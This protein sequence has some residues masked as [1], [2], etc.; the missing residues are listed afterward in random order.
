MIK[1]FKKFFDF[2][3]K[4]KKRFYVSLIFSLL[5]SIFEASRI[6]AIAVVLKAVIKDTMSPS[7]IWTSLLIMLVSIAG[8]AWT[9]KVTT[10]QQTIAGYT[11]CADK[12]VEIGERMKYMPMGYFNNNNLGHIASIT[13]NTC[14]NLQDI[15]T[16]VI[17]MYLQGMLTTTVISILLLVFDVRIGITAVLGILAFLLLNHQMQK[18][19]I[20]ISPKKTIAD[21]ALVD[22]VLEY[23]QGITV[24][25]SYNLGK[26]ANKKVDRKIDEANDICYTL[27][28]KFI[29]FMCGQTVV[30]KLFAL[31]MIT[32]SVVF[33]L[34]GSM[35]LIN[36]LLMIISSFIVYGQ[37]E[38]AGMYSALLRVVDQS[39][40]HIAEIFDTPVMDVN[41]VKVEPKNH[42][43]RAE[44]VT[45]SYDDRKII[46][47]V[48]FTIP[49]KTT[50]AIVG[51]SGGGKTTICSLISRF[52]DVNSGSITIG[53]RNVKE[54]TLDSLL[55]NISMVFQN[56]YLFHDTIENNIKFGKPDATRE[57]V[58]EAAKKACCHEFIENLPDGYQTVI[59]EA[60]AT[61]SGGEK[62]RISIARAILKDAPIIILD[63]ATANVDPENEKHLQDAI[64]ELTKDK[65][66]IMIA[67]RL[68]TVRSASQILVLSGGNILQ[69]G[70]HEQLMKEGGIYADFVNMRSK[71]IG[72]KLG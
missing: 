13:T 67:H 54:Y 1:I 20:K 30:F 59:G 10:M 40:D 2:S 25:K 41:G 61:I 39:V 72:W 53:G 36:A 34:N 43:I 46:D 31:L 8:C 32:L 62:Q 35:S 14:E 47:D 42:D 11:M 9:R 58:I 65:T 27:E 45:F 50:T 55:N 4:Q 24:V 52:W 60:G 33:C 37:L 66:I 5:H 19:S 70:N 18:V 21:I 57:Q 68:K 12:R 29:P 49:E 56:V 3:G 22:A 69:R 48:S 44:H 16:R 6:V 71:S 63:E 26:Q 38:S 64:A 15:A 23:V 17:L 7:V 28:K 51:P